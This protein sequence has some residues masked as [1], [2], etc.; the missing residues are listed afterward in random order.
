MRSKAPVASTATSTARNLITKTD[1]SMKMR[2]HCG[3]LLPVQILPYMLCVGIYNV[4]YCI[5]LYCFVLYCIVLYYAVLYCIV[6]YA[7]YF[8]A[9]KIK[10]AQSLPL[11]RYKHSAV[12]AV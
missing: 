3:Q 9:L 5:V 10:M 7:I 12:M 8:R 11:Q 4:L 1:N 2:L 6:L